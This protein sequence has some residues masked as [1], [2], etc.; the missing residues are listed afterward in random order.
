MEL[1]NALIEFESNA[2]AGTNILAQFIEQS[3][4]KRVFEKV[5]DKIGIK[6]KLNPFLA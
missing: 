3:L 4:K 1:K 6:E 2:E 5:F